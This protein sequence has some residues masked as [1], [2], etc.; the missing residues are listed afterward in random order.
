LYFFVNLGWLSKKFKNSLI[1]YCRCFLLLDPS[2]LYPSYNLLKEINKKE[3]K[4]KGIDYQIVKEKYEDYG[5]TIA[6][7]KPEG[8][9]KVITNS[10][11]KIYGATIVGEQAS[12]LIHEWVL[13]IQHNI[14]MFDIMVTQHSFPTISLMNK[15]V[16][17]KWMMN[18]TNSGM[19]PKLAKKFI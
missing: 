3:A 10:K 15:R 13:A 12:E 7:G 19:V 17:E 6:D 2:R 16:A 18:K 8:F 1:V 14:S 11:G 9:V 5:R 4:E